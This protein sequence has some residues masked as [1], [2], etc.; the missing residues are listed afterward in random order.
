MDIIRLDHFR[1]FAGYWEVPASEETAINGRWLPGPG[2]PIFNALK[3]H[4][5][6]LPLIAEDLG[7]ITPDVVELRER[8]GLPGMKIFQFGLEGGND[9]PFVPHNFEENC[10]AYTGTH[11]NDTSAGWYEKAIPEHQG[12]AQLLP[13]RGRKRYSGQG[14]LAD[15]REAVGISRE[16]NPGPNAGFPR[17]GH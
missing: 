7:V 3:E 10:V 8:F 6:A 1:G 15:D 17:P 12:F 16:L 5:G 14:R 4:L 2:A 11:D 13:G 9:D